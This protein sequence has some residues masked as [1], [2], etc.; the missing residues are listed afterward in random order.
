[1]LLC[2]LPLPFK[3]SRLSLS[4]SCRFQSQSVSFFSLPL[5]TVCLLVSN[6]CEKRSFCAYK[7]EH[8]RSLLQLSRVNFHDW[9]S[10]LWEWGRAGIP[11]RG[12]LFER[13]CRDTMTCTWGCLGG[14]GISWFWSFYG[15]WGRFLRWVSW[16]W[17]RTWCFFI[18]VCMP[19]Q[20]R[21]LL[22][23]RVNQWC[24]FIE[25]RLWGYLNWSWIWEMFRTWL[26]VIC[27]G[28]LGY[29][30]FWVWF[31]GELRWVWLCF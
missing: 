20:R 22:V 24:I 1:M 5:S 7:S 21:G 28:V 11:W 9:V 17:L 29:V 31:K 6:P 25:M 27:R 23:P 19:L 26:R 10:I 14:W 18:W 8:L 16:F 12:N 13:F 30:W 3:I 2:L 15:T 4:S